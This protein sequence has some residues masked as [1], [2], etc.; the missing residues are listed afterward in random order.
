MKS[1]TGRQSEIVH[2]V[3]QGLQHSPFVTVAALAQQMKLAG[4]SSLTPTLESIE[5]KGYLTIHRQGKGQSRL[6]ELTRK[7]LA[8][9]QSEIANV[10]LPV[11]GTIPA[12][13]PAEATEHIIDHIEL[14]N[15]LPW[16]PGDWL[17]RV[18]RENGDSM[19]DLGILPGAFVLLRP[20]A[21]IP[22][23]KIV[24]AQKWD[25]DWT[26]CESTLKIARFQSGEPMITLEPANAE[27]QSFQWPAERVTFAGRCYGWFYRPE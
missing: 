6:I 2:Q 25:D 23:G 27:Y 24:A 9:V 15:T 3:W 13:P 14:G 21:N 16:K 12:G 20:E 18:D 1:L 19:R 7:G 5:R 17:L 26:T 22:T 4:E 10:G 8:E 11:L